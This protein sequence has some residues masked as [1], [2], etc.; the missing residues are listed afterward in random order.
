MSTGR[1]DHHLECR[2]LGSAGQGRGRARARPRPSRTRSSLCR[3][4]LPVQE[5]RMV[6]EALALVTYPAGR[7][8]G[9]GRSARRIQRG[10]ALVGGIPRSRR[11]SVMPGFV[12]DGQLKWLYQSAGMYVNPSLSEGFGLAGPRGHDRGTAGPVPTATCLPEVYGD[13]AMYFDPHDAND[14]SKQI[15]DLLGKAELAIG[16]RREAG[17]ESSDVLVAQDSGAHPSGIQGCRAGGSAILTHRRVTPRPR[18]QKVERTKHS[19]AP[20]RV[21]V[22]GMPLFRERTGVGQYTKNLLE[23]LFRLDDDQ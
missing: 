6:I 19:M 20:M 2:R 9:A 4:L 18:G 15:A 21:F 22:D 3:Q 5:C 23:A 8:V 17:I 11:P 16:C 10:P 14:L 7:E 1:G 12:T 13:A